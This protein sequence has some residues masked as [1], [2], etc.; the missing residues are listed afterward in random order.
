M[1]KGDAEAATA[2]A[3]ATVRVSKKENEET[4][5]L[6]R[7]LGVPV[8]EAPGEAE[9]QCAA[10]V[11]EGR[12]WAAGT[13]DMDVLTFGTPLM[14]RNLGAA[15][16]KKLPIRQVDLSA[17]LTIL[18]FTMEQFIDM[19][20]LCGCDYT[21]TLKGIGPKT[22]LSLIRK[23]KTIEA[24]LENIDLAKH[25]VPEDFNYVEARRLFVTPEVTP[26]KEVAIK[27]KSPDAEGLKKYL[28]DE[29]GFAPE[30]VESALKRIKKAKASGKAS[31]GRLDSFFKPMGGDAAKAKLK[32]KSD[33]MAAKAKAAKAAKAK[34]KRDA[35]KRKLGK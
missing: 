25:P 32:R 15:P 18:E 29:K 34:E 7:L 16:A 6:L 30:T 12:V 33:A 24:V 14:V 5:R 11:K 3:R 23:H 27:F 10:L 9:A 26:A 28:V 21:S 17:L 1:E 35:K 19:C 4:R 22:A 2:A 8:I 31:Q 13:E 20:I